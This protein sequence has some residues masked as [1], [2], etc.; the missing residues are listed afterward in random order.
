MTWNLRLVE[1]RK[2]I[3]LTRTQLSELLGVSTAALSQWET[4]IT[5]DLS[6]DNLLSV[7]DLLKVT[8][9][10]LARGE[11]FGPLHLPQD[12][13]LGARIKAAR[14]ERRMTQEELGERLAKTKGAVSQWETNIAA[15]SADIVESLADALGV[16]LEWLLGRDKDDLSSSIR[17]RAQL[18][19][20]ELVR[21]ISAA[22]S[23]DKLSQDQI[24]LMDDLLTQ[25]IRTLSSPQQPRLAENFSEPQ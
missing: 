11:G 8:P 23:E 3:G 19:G 1:A 6:S 13:N 10:W 12:L 14:S 25:L 4:G 5:Q 2:A 17:K 21:R 24:Y 7:C 9:R 16:T 22:L 15:P 20:I 18:S